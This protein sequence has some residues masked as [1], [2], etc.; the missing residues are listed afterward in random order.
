LNERHDR[1][2][3]GAGLGTRVEAKNQ[4]RTRRKGGTQHTRTERGDSRRTSKR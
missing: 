4:G 3:M 1:Q 2:N